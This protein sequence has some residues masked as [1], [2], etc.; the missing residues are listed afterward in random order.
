MSSANAKTKNLSIKDKES[1]SKSN[2]NNKSEN[3]RLAL[4]IGTNSLGWAIY[5]LDENKKPKSIVGSGVR[6]FPSGRKPKDY[7]TL[8]VKRRESR[9]Q[10]RQRDRYLQR[11]KYLLHLLF[12][13]GLFP[14]DK[15]SAKKLEQLNPYEL[16]AK[17]LDEKLDIHHFGRALFH[18][19]QKR[20]FK[21]NRKSTN[22]KED[23]LIATSVKE[24]RKAMEESNSRT[25]GE[26]LWKRFQKMEEARKTPSS[27]EDN[28]VLARRPI[29][30]TSKETYAVY[31][32][33]SMMEEEFNK[34]WD[35]QS[36]FHEK[37]KD[38]KLKEKF[39]K[40]IFWQRQLKKPIVGICEFT[41]ETRIPKSSPYFQKF[42][43][44]KELNNLA[45]FNHYKS[46]SIIEMERGLE[47]RDHLIENLFRKK[48]KVTFKLIE[49]E[50]KNFFKEVDD[51]VKFNLEANDRKSLEGDKTYVVLSEIIPN[52]ESWGL[53]IQDRFIELLEGEDEAGNF[54]KGD[55]EVLEDLKNFN[56]SQNLNL[57]KEDL[58]KC[59]KQVNKL[60][61]S[62]CMYSKTALKKIIPYL[63]QG[64]LED[65]AIP[66]A[67]YGHHSDRGYKGEL[68]NRLPRYQ[69]ALKDHCVEMNF[70]NKLKKN[71]PTFRITNP[72]VHIALN[73][74]RLVVNDLIRVYGRPA[75]IV[76]ETARD[77]PLGKKTKDELNKK[78]KDNET[79]NN[80]ARKVIEEFGGIDN[81]ANRIRYQLWKDQKETCLYSGKKIKKSQIY[82]AE[83]EVDHI[84]PYSKTLDDSFTNKALVYKTF[85]QKKG[86]QT[87][88]ECF[89]SNEEQW[90][91]IL[92]NVPQ[93]KKWRF[94]KDAMEKF[95]KNGDFLERQLNDTRYISRYM[96]QYLRRI[97]E[98]IWTARGQTTS[99]LRTLLNYEAKDRCDHRHH[100][101]DALVIGLIDRS[102]VKK[103]SDKAKIM[104][105]KDDDPN[106]HKGRLES[107]G[108]SIK[109]NVLPWPSFKEDAKESIDK[110][111]VSH[112]KS[113][114]KEGQLH[115]ETA[116]GISKG[117]TDFK[118]LVDV[119]HYID[120]LNVAGKL[121]K[122]VSDKIRNDLKKELEK[123]GTISKEFLIGYH[124]DTG[125][126]RVKIKEK[127]TVIPIKNKAGKVY[128]A[129]NGD[130]NYALYLFVDKK[131]KWDA[132]VMDT[133]T[134]NQKGFVD[135]AGERLVRG[136]MF[137]FDN[138]F[139]RLVK[140]DQ[141]KNM[142]FSEHFESNV[143]ARNRDKK[144]S[145]KYTYKI[146][147]SFQK[148]NPKRVYIS[149]SGVYK[150]VDF[151]FSEPLKSKKAI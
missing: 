19:N 96:T 133:F 29:G 73:Q 83:L 42:R 144:D 8:N 4:D 51:F 75:Q 101:K 63:E 91:H 92:S 55:E 146:P 3:L 142:T 132:Q 86:N 38:K 66:R 31:A 135:P 113:T 20:G 99:I 37:L 16:R 139:W 27:Q 79:R 148:M 143:D 13:H 48:L 82:T 52:W 81:R 97:C 24:S 78:Q 126:R 5:E 107:I 88:F 7:T 35:K 114:K 93:Y 69:K 44:L 12:K 89:S 59:L 124:K 2:I 119:F 105:V 25:Y 100:A 98:E 71:S 1:N 21:S 136:D 109:K 131:G 85:N 103:I 40:A 41:K 10:R 87:P 80:E 104:E 45:Y 39:F 36:E 138:K 60:P 95:N 141:N 68:Q 46:H 50:F 94:E 137:F 111:V 62:H 43:I 23:G 61:Q 32:Q 150:L 26:F 115:N 56:D 118:K 22:D 149:P 120:L 110:I 127:Q 116:Y 147:G 76:V 90:T 70:N 15:F 49:K 108:K 47:F 122:I 134:A 30:A 112:K 6:I 14:E 74:V 34:L 102:F 130:G 72:T 53:D 18:I 33:R 84:L 28:W 129:F 128:K 77:L 11:R 17:G 145:Y 121:D 54:M 58:D 57:S 64:M 140:Y 67:G 151:K 117:V 123:S 106:P 125:V 9:L 65:E